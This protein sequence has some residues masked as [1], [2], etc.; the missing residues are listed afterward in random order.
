MKCFVIFLS[1][2]LSLPAFSKDL[3]QNIF[4][5]IL[6]TKGTPSFTLAR[7]G[8]K[9]PGVRPIRRGN[10]FRIEEGEDIIVDFFDAV[11]S[12]N[13]EKAI[14]LL[15]KKG[16]S[17]KDFGHS[18]FHL[19]VKKGDRKKAGALLNRGVD[20]NSVNEKKRTALHIATLEGD[21]DMV[22]FLLKKKA[23]K[24]LLDHQGKTAEELA[25]IQKD[26][27]VLL[28]FQLYELNPQK[29]LSSEELEMYVKSRID[30]LSLNADFLDS[31][32][33]IRNTMESEVTP[34]SVKDQI[35]QNIDYAVGELVGTLR[36]AGATKTQ[37]SEV[38]NR[39]KRAILEGKLDDPKGRD[40]N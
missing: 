23:D 16:I 32:Q 39:I 21:F 27:D 37:I 5:M 36:L 31:A 33:R 34:Q 10:R 18:V 8:G 9:R 25:F 12:E 19:A 13:L 7:G 1:F 11:R 2:L 38:K 17:I 24:T 29:K 4:N 6:S 28:A 22:H 20:I 3:D 30:L 15:E 26:T 35:E 40:K 14:S